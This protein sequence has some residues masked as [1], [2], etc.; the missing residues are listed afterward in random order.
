VVASSNSFWLVTYSDFYNALPSGWHKSKVAGIEGVLL[1]KENK[2]G[3]GRVGGREGKERGTYLA[4]L[5]LGIDEDET[6][7]CGHFLA[8]SEESL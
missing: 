3:R 5:I 4:K 6:S 8:E 1:H 2:R 7:L